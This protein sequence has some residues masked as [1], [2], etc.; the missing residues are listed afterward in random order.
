M[1][2]QLNIQSILDNKSKYHSVTISESGKGSFFEARYYL[3]EKTKTGIRN[4]IKTEKFLTVSGENLLP[5][6]S[7]HTVSHLGYKRYFHIK[8]DGFYLNLYFRS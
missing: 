4:K 2:K 6:I 7:N 1:K 5:I 8:E 3:K